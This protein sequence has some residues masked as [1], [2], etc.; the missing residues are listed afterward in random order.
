M[1]APEGSA[2]DSTV[3]LF[4]YQ[5]NGK[6][7]SFTAE[8][9]P[10]DFDDTYVFVKREDKVVRKGTA[11]I[12]IRDFSLQTISGTD[13][14]LTLLNE[15]GYKLFLFIK[16]GYKPGEWIN[17]ME[18]IIRQA[19]EK[20]IKG[21]MVTNLEVDAHRQGFLPQLLPLRTDGTAIK[22]AARF[23]PTL[24]LVN[25]GTIIGKWSAV[26]FERALV[27]ISQIP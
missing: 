4:T 19:T 22:T 1:K 14:T 12:P 15:P 23:N 9:F 6:Q 25:Q 2:P 3:I 21:F 11:V 8:N 17:L 18:I 16:D 10:A 27:A 13:T 7:L 20:N 24:F 26:D 5:K